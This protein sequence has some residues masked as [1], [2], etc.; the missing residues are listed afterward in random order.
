MS[1]GRV[2]VESAHLIVTLLGV[3]L[4]VVVPLHQCQRCLRGCFAEAGASDFAAKW[5]L[6]LL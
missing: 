1:A 5:S 3:L 4:L 2:P 6:Q